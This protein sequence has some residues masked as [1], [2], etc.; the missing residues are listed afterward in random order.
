MSTLRGGRAPVTG[1]DNYTLREQLLEL[2]RLVSES[3]VLRGKGS[4]QGIV[5]ANP[6]TLYIDPSGGANATLWVKETGTGKTGWAAK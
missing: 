3:A 5:A 4:P 1:P 6:G 2:R